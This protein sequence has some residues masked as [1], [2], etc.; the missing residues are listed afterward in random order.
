MCHLGVNVKL[1]SR[2]HLLIF[3]FQLQKIIEKLLFFLMF[4]R[5]FEES[6][7]ILWERL[8]RLFWNALGRLWG[9]LGR[10]WGVFGE[11]LGGL[12]NA[13]GAPWGGLGYA[14]GRTSVDERFSLGE[15]P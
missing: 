4:F 15:T 8:G 10:P 5:C 3:H 7:G 9:F 11:A 6:L 12:G 2:L 14:L 13:L 1:F